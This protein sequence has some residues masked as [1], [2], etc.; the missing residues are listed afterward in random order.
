VLIKDN[1]LA[2]TCLEDTIKNAKS[3]HPGKPV[4]VEVTTALDAVK[5]AQMGADIIMLDNFTAEAAK[6]AVETL[7][8]EGLREQVVIELSGGI[9]KGNIEEYARAGADRI[10]LGSLTTDARWLDFSLKIIP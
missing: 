6:E 5:A 3:E 2:L 10:S 7:K 1:H 4:E 8:K 9:N